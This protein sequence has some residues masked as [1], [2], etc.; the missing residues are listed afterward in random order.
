MSLYFWP[1]SPAEASRT[2]SIEKAMST[3]DGIQAR[4][5][6]AL[7]NVTFHLVVNA[8]RDHLHYPHNFLRNIAMDNAVTDYLLLLDADL[9]PP[10]ASH[11]ALLKR[12]KT[13][14]ELA[15]DE[16][17]VLVLPAFERNQV[18]NESETSLTAFDLPAS[19]VELL[20]QM[21]QNPTLFDVFH[22]EWVRCQGPTNYP[23]WYGANEIYP[24]KYRET[25]EPYFVVRR[26]DALPPFWEHFTGYGRD[27]YSWVKEV[28]VAGFHFYV[29]PD[30]FLIHINHD[31]SK[32]QDQTTERSVIK[33]EYFQHFL[34]YLERIYGK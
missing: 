8:E 26:I 11:D 15:N 13:T 32:Q 17:A 6:V 20:E 29:S 9:V 28:S 21:N 24:V 2:A 5:T 25:Y 4:Y 33:H 23:M 22:P 1:D 14:P 3:V 10:P 16:R 19:K 18:G 34:P 27:K 12:F 31:R 7:Q 30:M